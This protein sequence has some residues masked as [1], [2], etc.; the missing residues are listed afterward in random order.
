MFKNKKG[1][2]LVEILI[3]VAIIAIIG[4]LAV[5]AVNS[6]RSKQRDATRLSNVRQMQSALEDYFNETNEYPSGELLPLGDPSISRCL[7]TTGFH[8]DCSGETNTIVRNVP[9]TYV[10]GLDGIVTCGNP[11]RNAFC[12]TQLKDGDS[13]VIHFELENGLA[14]V[15]LQSGVNCAVPGKME[16]GVCAEEQD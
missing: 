12:F 1:F 7:G 14:G 6:A 3:V 15:G 13:Y 2:T 11:M 10:P 4:T 9:G 8:G 16:A 5:L